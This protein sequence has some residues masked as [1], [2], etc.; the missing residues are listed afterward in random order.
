MSYRADLGFIDA[1]CDLDSAAFYADAMKPMGAAR[2]L[3]APAFRSLVF[4][5]LEDESVWTRCWVCI[6]TQAE[7]PEPGD[8]LPFTL[9]E[10]G[11]HVQRMPDGGLQG[12]FNKAQHG[13]CRVVPLQCQGG[14]KTRCSFTS[15]GHSRDR[16][17]IAANASGLSSPEMHQYLGL[18]PERLLPVAVETAGDFVFVCLDE[19]PMPLAADLPAD[20]PVWRRV[21]AGAL[22]GPQWLEFDANWKLV[23][24]SLAAGAVLDA[25]RPGCLRTRQRLAAGGASTTTWLFPSLLL[26][27]AGQE[28][29][30]LVLQ[31]T[32]IGR[33]L[34]RLSAWRS[35]GVAPDDPRKGLDWHAELR[36]RVRVAEGL[37]RR[38]ADV[39]SQ[40]GAD[41]APVQR[42]P[43]GLWMQHTLAQQVLGRQRRSTAIPMFL[44]R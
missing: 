10:H 23:A 32:A 44:Q 33:T 19:S 8:L 39:P 3:P 13:G 6:G 36:A 18:R 37:Q 30:S 29:V 31:P 7:I 15:C 14:T 43:V 20:D 26:L 34:V 40:P 1:G 21:S 12:R 25:S 24:Q 17:A 42:D 11:I 38:L 16:P 4:S 9:G 35:S 41:M 28:R 27:E 2:C 5:R 22:N